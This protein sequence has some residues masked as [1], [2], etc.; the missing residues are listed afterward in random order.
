M[1]KKV[2]VTGA[3]GFVGKYM[4]DKLL[5]SGHDVR[6]VDFRPLADNDPMWKDVEFMQVDIRD[7]S[8]VAEACKGM[9]VVYH[10][11]AIP[12]IARAKESDY[13]SIN[14]DGTRNVLEE[15]KKAGA[16]CAVH[17]S[18]ST[19]YGVP[20]RFPLKEDDELRGVGFYGKSKIAAEKVCF[21]IS[22]DDF[23]V[24]IIRPRVVM[25]P[26]RIGIFGLLFRRVLES[27][28]VYILGSGNNRFQFTD[29]RDMVD[30]VVRAASHQ[31]VFNVGSGKMTTVRED[32]V[33]LI[34]HAGSKSKIISLP[35]GMARAALK[36]AS[37]LGI[38]P[39]M[40]EQFKI[41]DKDF[42][43]DTSRAERELGWKATK[44][45]AE[46]LIDAYDW[47]VE[48]GELGKK[49]FKFIFGVFGKFTHSQQGGFQK[50]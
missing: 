22:S 24:S 6:A 41:A 47:F 17:V 44:S 12:S 29:V 31:G 30:A 8:S 3:T 19:V 11:A 20:C 28:P 7:R 36:L 14:V 23:P 42:W 37:V 16:G 33:K 49:Q 9:E 27:K 46:T 48:H 32:L 1:S 35:A 21:E 45:N 18:S 2:L 13:M 38:S 5:S 10:L 39:L 43:L 25:G 15:A 40:D 4:V 34:E 50:S 26:G